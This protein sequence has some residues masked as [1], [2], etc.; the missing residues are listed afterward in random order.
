MSKGYKLYRFEDEQGNLVL[1]VRNDNDGKQRIMNFF[2]KE[3]DMINFDLMK[4]KH[5]KKG[6]DKYYMQIIFVDEEV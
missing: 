6:K 2:G 4:Y 3:L 1:I 5:I